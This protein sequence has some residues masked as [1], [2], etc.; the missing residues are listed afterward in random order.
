MK[1]SGC[2]L[3]LTLLALPVL[4][5]Q[6]FPPFV[7]SAN[8][9]ADYSTTIAQG[10]LFVVFGDSMGPSPL[11]EVTMFPLPKAL[12]GTSVTVTSGATTLDC[13]MIYT[14][15]AQVAA[16]LP[17]NTP[18]GLDTI[19]VTYNGKSDP[20]VSTTKVTVVANSPGVYTTTESGLGGGSLTDLNYTLL[21]FANSA[22]PGDIVTAWG[23]GLGPIS[24]PDNVAPPVL[25]FP[26]VQVW[27]GGQTA[28]IVYAGRGCCAG[29]DQIS[30]KVPAVANGCNLPVTVVS[31]GSSSNTVTLA[32]NATG[33]PCSDTGPTFSTPVLTKAAAGQEVKGASILIGPGRLGSRTAANQAMAE[34]LAA[35]LLTRV[36]AEDAARLVRAYKSNNPRALRAAMAK[37]ARQWKALDGR[38]KA[39]L[40]AQL[41]QTQEGVAATFGSFFDESNVAKIA[42]AQFPVAGSC[43]L[44]PHKYPSGLGSVIGSLDAGATL[45]LTGAAGSVKLNEEGLGQYRASFGGSITGPNVPLGSYTLTGSGGKDVGAFSATITVAGHLAISNKPSLATV[46]RTQPLTVTWTGGVA[47]SF[48]L[49]GGYTPNTSFDGAPV[50]NSYF[51]CA[52]DGGKGTFTIPNYILASMNATAGA[53]GVVLVMPHPLSNLVA[54]PGL[55]FAYFSDGSSDSADVTFK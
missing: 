1:I 25:R 28:S 29:E 49:I 11:V 38:T 42:S 9:S 33:G 15:N 39:K 4:R 8:N 32:V 34:R 23:T 50:P 48:V 46:D 24:T 30:F 3:C 18:V 19:T 6:N 10:S 44:L 12:S 40:T 55:D 22:K 14:S 54:I 45:T 21:T 27:V 41:G 16:I 37:F 47:G 43:V 52:E 13:P 5:A 35:A 31:N 51:A 17:S 53:T 20:S 36:T 26:N 2:F 7:K